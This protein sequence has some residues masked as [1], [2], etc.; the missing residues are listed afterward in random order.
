MN[1]SVSTARRSV[2]EQVRLEAVL[3]EVF[4]HSS[5][6]NEVLGIRV[7]S[8]DPGSPQLAFDMRQELIGSIHHNRRL[9]GG[10]I[11]S[12]LDTI[13]GFAVA[14]AIA[15]KYAEET[16]EQI[17]IRFGRFATIDMQVNYLHQGI[18]RSFHASAKVVRLGGRIASVQMEL[19]NEAG[20]LIATGTA[21][22]IVS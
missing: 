16:S 13:G 15:E 17:V 2:E 9:H 10:A 11:A 21:A 4:E 18:G 14:V 20:L 19:K 22:Y 8:L 1:S 5:P 12:A 7:E 3:R 6:F